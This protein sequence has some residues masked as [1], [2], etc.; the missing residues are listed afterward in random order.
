MGRH[1]GEE[2]V[3]VGREGYHIGKVARVIY[4]CIYVAIYIVVSNF[5]SDVKA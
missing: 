5:F 2:C 3:C 1:G 4:E